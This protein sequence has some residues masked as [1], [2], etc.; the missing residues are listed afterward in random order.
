MRRY[1]FAGFNKECMAALLDY[2]SFSIDWARIE[3][4]KRLQEKAKTK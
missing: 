3:N 1:D 2:G 4:S